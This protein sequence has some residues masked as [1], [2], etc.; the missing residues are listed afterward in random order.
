[1]KIVI[2]DR[3]PGVDMYGFYAD[4]WVNAVKSDSDF[5]WI[6]YES[7]RDTSRW[8]SKPRSRPFLVEHIDRQNK[9]VAWNRL[10]AYKT[11][12]LAL[13]AATKYAMQRD[14]YHVI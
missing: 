13:A 12:D 11:L 5:L 14:V 4:T 2:N 7:Y 8:K 1:M 9:R 3:T 6:H 10:G